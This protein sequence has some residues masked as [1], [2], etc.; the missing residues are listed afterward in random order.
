[1]RKPQL[2]WLSSF[3]SFCIQSMVRRAL[4]S[5]SND[6]HDLV[7][8]LGWPRKSGAEWYLH[9]P[10]RLFFAVTAN[11]DPLKLRSESNPPIPLDGQLTKKDISVVK[12][13]IEHTRWQENGITSTAIYLR[14]LFEIEDPQAIALEIP[15]EGAKHPAN[16][17][18]SVK[19]PYIDGPSPNCERVSG[20]GFSCEEHLNEHL[21]RVHTKESDRRFGVEDETLR[22]HKKARSAFKCPAPACGKR[23]SK[24]EV[25]D[26]L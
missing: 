5:F 26:H 22:R 13:A 17:E 16:R 21:R 10:L 9:R 4:L 24:G 11:F 19:E 8:S 23:F 6:I 2:W 25:V 15:R 3:Y 18:I 7:D 1:M 12:Q 14:R 20:R